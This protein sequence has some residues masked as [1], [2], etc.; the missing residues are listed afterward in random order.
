MTNIETQ[1]RQALKQH[2]GPLQPPPTTK[3]P[4]GR[5]EK[6]SGAHYKNTLTQLAQQTK[7]DPAA[8]SR[9]LHNKRTLT[10]TTAAKLAHHL[11]LQLTK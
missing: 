3:K 5:V 6:T 9:F 11:K 8:L 4:N 2:L 1:L 7:I 10:L